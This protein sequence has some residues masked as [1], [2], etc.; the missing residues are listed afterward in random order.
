MPPEAP[1]GRRVIF[2]RS[3][4]RRVCL[5]VVTGRRRPA[6]HGCSL[7][8]RRAVGRRRREA[9]QH[10]LAAAQPREHLDVAAAHRRCPRSR[11]ATRPCRPASRTTTIATPP[12]RST[13]CARHARPPSLAGRRPAPGRSHRWRPR[14]PPS[15][16]LDGKVWVIGSAPGL[17]STTVPGTR[18]R[19]GSASMRHRQLGARRRA[20]GRHRRLSG[21]ASASRRPWSDSSI[22]SG[23]PGAARS[24][25]ST[26]RAATRPA[27]GATTRDSRA[28]D[29]A[30]LDRALRLLAPRPWPARTACAPC[31]ARA[32]RPAPLG[33]ERLEALVVALGQRQRGLRLRESAARLGLLPAR[34]LRGRSPP[35]PGRPAPRRPA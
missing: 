19:S 4:S 6:A 29:A 30:A 5:A 11:R 23:R 20:R 26:S 14:R 35:A 21:T 8:D 34:G 12:A 27:N 32:R 3:A 33:C 17:I 1:S 9:E 25:T 16:Q 22:T 2:R 13:A 31:R 18:P 10:V 15:V 28:T 7:L 24:P